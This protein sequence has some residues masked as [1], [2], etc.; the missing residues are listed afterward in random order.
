MDGT[1][2]APRINAISTAVPAG[3]IEQ[4]YRGWVARLLDGRREAK[5]FA[6]MAER[7]GIA[8]RYSVLKKHEGA[9]SED[10]FHSRA[11]V[12]STRE[13]MAIYAEEAPTLACE[14]VGGLPSLE[15]VTH[16][17]TAS[18]TGFLAPGLDQVVVRRLGLPSSVERISIGFMGCYAGATALR[19]AGHIVRSR[20]DARVLVL[21][22]ELC[23][24]HL[25]QTE[26]LESLLAMAQFADGAAAALVSG[27][28]DGLAIGEGLSETLE[29][30]EELITWTIGDTG[31]AMNL[32]GEVPNRFAAALQQDSLRRQLCESDWARDAAAW[33]VHPGGR[34]V[35]D[36]VERGLSLPENSL[37]HSRDVLHT[38]GNMSS[39]TVV[40]VLDRVMR[41]RP[42]SGLALAFGPGLA[43]EGFRFSWCGDAG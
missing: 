43:L 14:A 7:S 35:L 31:F 32:S 33:A 15:G 34:S 16:L 28:G 13:R 30:S 36:A 5:L 12:P 22:V 41:D 25:Q 18:C 19:T 39:A 3:D 17:V 4:D 38:Y 26:A 27:D 1:H 2:P 37:R 11:L 24:L 9:I 10:E 23:S 21:C 29:E 42:E 20:P 40:F 6:R 8:H